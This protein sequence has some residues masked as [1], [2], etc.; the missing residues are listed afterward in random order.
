MGGIAALARGE[1]V[2]LYAAAMRG[3]FACARICPPCLLRRNRDRQ[4]LLASKQQLT[5]ATGTFGS[6]PVL[7]QENHSQSRS[8]SVGY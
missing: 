2:V 8:E 1:F 4:L 6:W 3:D 5:T 7:V